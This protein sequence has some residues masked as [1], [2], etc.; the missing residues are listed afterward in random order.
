MKDEVSEFAFA[1]GK[2]MGVYSAFK[3]NPEAI[4]YF[5]K[6]GVD[7]ELLSSWEKLGLKIA[8]AFYHKEFK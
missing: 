2:V 8:E 1:M 7:Q 3:H 5:E 6:R 4:A